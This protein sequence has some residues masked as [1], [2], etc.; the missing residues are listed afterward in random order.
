[1]PLVLG[2]DGRRLAKRHG[3]VTL[4]ELGAEAALAWMAD[5]LGLGGRTAAELLDGFDPAAIGR[6]PT[7][8]RP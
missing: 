4:R 5:S 1:M 6:Q 7:T 2:A 3:D 8:L